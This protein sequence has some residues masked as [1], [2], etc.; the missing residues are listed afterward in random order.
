MSIR[1]P[2]S[3]HNSVLK[4]A[5]DAVRPSLFLFWVIALGACSKPGLQT[6]AIS[7]ETMGT[8]Y[9]VTLVGKPQQLPAKDV[10]TD[11]ADDEFARINQSM[12][13]YIP[14]SELSVIN[15]TEQQGW[16]D[17]S[18]DLYEVLSKGQEISRASFGAFDVT[19]MPLVD[20]WGFGPGPHDYNIPDQTEINQT[21]ARI[22]YQKLEL[23]GELN[24]LKRPNGVAIDLSAIAKGYGA[25]ALGRVLKQKGF[26]HYLIEVGGELAASGLSARG[27]AWRVGVEYPNYDASAPSTRSPARTVMLTD[28][29][30]ATSGDYRNYYEIQGRR[31]SH[32]IDPVSGR[33][34]THNLAS[35]SVVAPS[36]AK[37]DAWAT[38][39]SVLGP[40]RGYQL[41]EKNGLAAYFIVGQEEGFQVLITP[42][43]E[44]YLFHEAAE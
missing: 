14:E 40:E 2:V 13:T 28:R 37:A 26:S 22:G 19:V 20:L 31:Y 7:G 41:A 10:L 11:W 42:E 38:A 12:S 43:F 44:Q 17:L 18:A 24:R 29:G 36:A 35:V 4:K 8:Y 15:R 16:F 30:M 34:V 27:D 25:D 9:R 3:I 1:N 6:V 5:R 33:P 23:D 21:L 32:T 39:L